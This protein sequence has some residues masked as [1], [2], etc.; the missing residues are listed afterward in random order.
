MSSI[1]NEVKFLTRLENL[2]EKDKKRFL[3]EVKDFKSEKPNIEFRDYP[4]PHIHDRFVISSN[5]IVLLGHSIKDLGSKESFAVVLNKETNR[6][7]FEALVRI[8]NE[9]WKKANPF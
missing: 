4:Y 7:F 1:S 2:R 8:F 5:N 3:R 9:K 6:D